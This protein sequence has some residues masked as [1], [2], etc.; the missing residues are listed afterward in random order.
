MLKSRELVRKT[1]EFENKNNRLPRELWVLPIANNLY[2][3]EL[4]KIQKRFPDDLG[5]LEAVFK[6][7]PL[8][9][10]DLYTPGICRDEWGCVFTN[11]QAGLVG[12]VKESLIDEEDLDW[13][14]TSR[15][16]FPYEWLT[17][18]IDQVNAQCRQDQRFL[19][20]P[21]VVRPFER[22]QFIRGTVGLFLDLME[23]RS[24]FLE[25]M[26]K[27][28]TFY[29]DLLEKWAKT[30]IDAL[31]FMDDWGSQNSLL[32]DPK[33]WRKLFAP[34]YKDYID[35]AKKHGKKAFM[36]SDGHILEILPDLVD[37]GLDAINSQ[38]FCM[39]LENLRPYKGKITFWGEIDRQHLL[40]FGTKEE[41]KNAVDSVYQNLWENGGCIAQCEFGAGARPENVYTVFEAWEKIR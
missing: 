24:G 17:F 12:E 16:H 11:I 13:S 25:F 3:T 33:I 18:A 36:H 34:M 1:L 19:L 28:H 21:T 4:Q 6:E 9:C 30:E 10:G 41:I 37:M 39:G 40:S 32:I 14:D 31:F 27:I 35:I 22:L 29:C 2:P 15:V 38:I 20:P 5:G 26:Q 8:T 7:K 23:Q